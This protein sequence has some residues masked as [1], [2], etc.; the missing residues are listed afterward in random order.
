MWNKT[1]TLL[2]AVYTILFLTGCGD[3]LQNSKERSP[4]DKLPPHIKQ[5]TH[6]GQR[7]DWSHD[8]K[9]ILFIEKTF[10]DVYEIGA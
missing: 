9:R 3:Q 5:I 8:G 6:F 1:C 4:L 7:A 10:G 2:L